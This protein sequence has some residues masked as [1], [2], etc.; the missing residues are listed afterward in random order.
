MKSYNSISIEPLCFPYLMKS[1][2]LL[3]LPKTLDF[4]VIPKHIA[5]TIV[6]LPVPFGPMITFRFGPGWNSSE[7]YVLLNYSERIKLGVLFFLDQLNQF[8]KEIL[9]KIFEFDA[10]DSTMGIFLFVSI[11]LYF[12][13]IHFFCC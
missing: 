2:I 1:A 9:H 10:K 8:K 3:C 6:D 11:V 5:H 7:S 12:L 13:P 4:P